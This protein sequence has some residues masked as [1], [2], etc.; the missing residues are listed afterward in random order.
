MTTN[1]IFVAFP[2]LK[3]SRGYY[4]GTAGN[5]STEIIRKYIEAQKYSGRR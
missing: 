5:V 2:W 1:R 3:W 4:I